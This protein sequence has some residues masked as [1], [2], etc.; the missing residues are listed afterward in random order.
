LGFAYERQRLLALAGVEDGD[1]DESIAIATE[2]YLVVG[3]LAVGGR[4]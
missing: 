4:D 2:D 3:K 1:A